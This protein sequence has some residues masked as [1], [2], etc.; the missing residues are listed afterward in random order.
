MDKSVF[1]VQIVAKIPEGSRLS[2]GRFSPNGSRDRAPENNRSPQTCFRNR[3]L[4]CQ[5]HAQ[6]ARPREAGA[7]TCRIVQD[8]NCLVIA[9]SD[10]TTLY[11]LSI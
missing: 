3:I 11:R 6:T 5:R 7:L 4:R 9:S 2:T 8:G 1:R 10:T